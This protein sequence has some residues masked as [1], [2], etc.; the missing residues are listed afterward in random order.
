LILAVGVAFAFEG[1]FF[2]ERDTGHTKQKVKHQKRA[3]Q[4]DPPPG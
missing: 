4:T 1:I 3:N 2:C